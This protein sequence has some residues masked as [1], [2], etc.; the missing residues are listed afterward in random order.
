MI[1]YS[2]PDLT[3]HPPRSPRVR[4]GGFAH[5][6]RLLDK[7]RAVCAG[8]NG[9]YKYDTM[10]DRFF[11]DFSGIKAPAFLKSVKS[12]KSDSEMLAWVMAHLKPPRTASEIVNW[13]SWLE[14][15]GPASAARHG[16]LAERMKNYG[17]TRE[18]VQTWCD[19]LDLDDF[20]AFGGKS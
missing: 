3:Q 18:D 19:H 11:F 4:L 17:P 16:W 12:G 1:D 7:A 9:E 14:T 2:Q 20:V 10:M 6:P 5:L 8:T 13:S 15:Q